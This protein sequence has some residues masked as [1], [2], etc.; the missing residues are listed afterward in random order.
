VQVDP[1]KHKLKAPGTYLL[2]PKYDDLLSNF[3]FKINLRHHTVAD[4]DHA[5]ASASDN[6]SVHVW[7]V[8]YVE[9]KPPPGS[10]AAATSSASEAGASTRPLLSAQPKPYLVTE[11]TASVH[12]SAQP[13]TCLPMRP[14]HIAR[15]ERSRRAEKWTSVVHRKCLR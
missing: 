2:T 13:E 14:L 8:E 15:K 3:A 7:R 4:D 10:A 5:V 1:I 12:S 11:A 6:G 9:R